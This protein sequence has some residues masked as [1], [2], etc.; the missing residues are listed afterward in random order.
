MGAQLLDHRGIGVQQLEIARE[1]GRRLQLAGAERRMHRAERRIVRGGKE[2]V[3]VDAL[4]RHRFLGLLSQQRQREPVLMPQR[5]LVDPR[6]PFLQRPAPGRVP[7]RVLR[8]QVGQP[9]DRQA[10][11][12][13]DGDVL[14]ELMTPEIGGDRRQLH[15]GVPGGAAGE[16]AG[17]GSG[18]PRGGGP[19]GRRRDAGG[20]R[21]GDAHEAQQHRSGHLDDPR[22]TAI[23][24]DHEP[25][26]MRKARPAPPAPKAPLAPSAARR[27]ARP[28]FEG[29]AREWRA[30]PP[31]D[32]ITVGQRRQA[33][34]VSAPDGTPPPHP[35]RLA[36]A[37]A[38]SSGITWSLL[39]LDAPPGNFRPL[40]P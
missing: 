20:S 40:F 37:G 12:Q 22:K 18:A 32:W 2:Q 35:F 16:R 26:P 38:R 34:D 19:G 11:A 31:R 25:P 10:L 6:Q 3:P 27:R 7:G 8:R 9:L 17:P 4:R 21:A 30:P 24:R 14:V 29:E 5:R 15:R 28:R 39:R 33:Y 36:S 13:P 1:I 23:Q